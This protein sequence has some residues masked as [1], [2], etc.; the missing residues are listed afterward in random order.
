MQ[1]LI[2]KSRDDFEKVLEVLAADLRAV[3]TGRAKP[4]LIEEVGVEAYEGQPRMA[5]RE[6]ATI[7]VPDS[8]QLVVS[9]WD[10]SVVEKIEKA[11]SSADLNLSPVVDGDV[12]RI[13]IPALTE[14]VRRD[15]VKLVNQ[16]LES[17]RVLLRGARRAIKEE[18]DSKK[19]T[20]DVSKIGENISFKR[21]VRF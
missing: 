21:F 3:K 1:D 16:K 8:R 7:S 11:L 18:I 15:L 20:A 13:K 17:G 6:L 9:P 14:E 5:L 4:G 10:K 19:G 12:I 2:S